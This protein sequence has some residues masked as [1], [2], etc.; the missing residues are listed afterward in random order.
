MARRIPE[1]AARGVADLFLEVAPDLRRFAVKLTQG[2]CPAADDLVQEVFHDA[3]LAWSVLHERD[4][5][6]RRAWLFTVVR[7]KAFSRWR[8]DARVEV[9]LELEPAPS[10]AE[11][12]WDKA[13]NAMT[14][15]R[16]WKTLSCMPPTRYRVAY[17]RWREQWSTA[18]IATL[19]EISPSTV[20][21]HLKNARDELVQ[22]LGPDRLVSPEELDLQHKNR[23]EEAS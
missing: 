13:F 7:N 8:A 20:R 18:E 19:L 2:D 9:G 5:G 3:A 1:Q 22:L 15:E 4:S 12:T 11:D 23:E 10:P 6:Q 16:C 21:V 17:L 14:L